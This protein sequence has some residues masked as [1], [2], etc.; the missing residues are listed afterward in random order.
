M[1]ILI[2]NMNFLKDGQ[3]VKSCAKKMILSFQKEDNEKMFT[4]FDI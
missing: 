4:I 2:G 3:Q 1:A